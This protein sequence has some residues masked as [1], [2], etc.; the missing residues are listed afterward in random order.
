M[1]ILCF[2]WQHTSTKTKIQAGAWNWHSTNTIVRFQVRGPNTTFHDPCAHNLHC[3]RMHVSTLVKKAQ[4]C[5]VTKTGCCAQLI[6]LDVQTYRNLLSICSWCRW[7]TR[8]EHASWK[9]LSL[10][11]ILCRKKWKYMHHQG[12]YC[13]CSKKHRELVHHLLQKKTLQFL[14]WGQKPAMLATVPSCSEACITID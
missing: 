9:S 13:G 7:V 14:E 6:E 12:H 1:C 3:T 10:E 11:K 5:F 8:N 4:T 2:P